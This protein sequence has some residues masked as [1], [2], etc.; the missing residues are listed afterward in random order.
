MLK[1][2]YAHI[3]GSPVRYLKNL[4]YSKNKIQIKENI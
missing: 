2:N 1:K 3:N 4:G